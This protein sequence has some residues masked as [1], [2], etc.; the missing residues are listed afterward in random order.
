MPLSSTGADACDGA[1]ERRSEKNARETKKTSAAD[2]MG[3][4]KETKNVGRRVSGTGKA[5]MP[6]DDVFV[7]FIRVGG[8]VAASHDVLV[9]NLGNP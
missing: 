4:T 7:G 6:A 1:M 2:G 5:N 3:K 9:R 8:I